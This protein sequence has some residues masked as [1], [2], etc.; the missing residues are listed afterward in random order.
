VPELANK[1]YKSL[2]SGDTATVTRITKEFY[3]PLVRLRSKKNGYAVSLIKAGAKLI[4]K[5]AGDV[6]PPL[7][8]PTD[9]EIAELKKIIE[10][11]RV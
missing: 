1:F 3:I 7:S 9:A 8:M 11:C 2:R 4:G 10:G 6:R 5:S